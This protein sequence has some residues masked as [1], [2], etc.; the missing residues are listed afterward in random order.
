MVSGETTFT[1]AEHH[2]RIRRLAGALKE[3]GVE[4][5]DR[6]A[7][8]LPNVTRCSSCTTR[9]PASARCWCRST[10]A[11]RAT[12]T[13]TSSSTPGAKLVF[14]DPELAELLDAAAA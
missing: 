9:C 11:S 12:T 6:V 3:L 8:L 13:P 14:A 10:R 7:T 1:Y 4:P 2:E 5:G